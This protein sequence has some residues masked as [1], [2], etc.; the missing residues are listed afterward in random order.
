MFLPAV[1]LLFTVAHFKLQPTRL[2][3]MHTHCVEL[4]QC[5]WLFN[6]QLFLFVAI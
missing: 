5:D 4:L 1:T 2:H 6:N 3:P